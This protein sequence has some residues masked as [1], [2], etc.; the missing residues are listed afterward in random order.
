MH[1][2][3]PRHHALSFR[4]DDLGVAWDRGRA[5]RSCVFDLAAS[6]NNRTIF[7]R[8]PAGSINNPRVNN[9]DGLFLRR[10][11]P[12]RTYDDHPKRQ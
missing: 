4:V 3:Q 5:G 8:R 7:G 2:R 9:R 6:K 1:V 12:K 11:L 10:Q